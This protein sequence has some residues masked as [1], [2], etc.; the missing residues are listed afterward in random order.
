MDNLIY[1][2]KFDFVK[3]FD[4]VSHTR[5]LQKPLTYAITGHILYITLKLIIGLE[6]YKEYF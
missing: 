2:V 1:I 5:L 6:K 3:A 4:T